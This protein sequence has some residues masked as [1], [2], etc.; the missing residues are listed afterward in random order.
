MFETHFLT[1]KNKEKMKQDHITS[2]MK[3]LEQI[4]SWPNDQMNCQEWNQNIERCKT[5]Y[6]SYVFFL[7]LLFYTDSMC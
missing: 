4:V 1:Q 5:G 2:L 7:Q 3:L 6:R